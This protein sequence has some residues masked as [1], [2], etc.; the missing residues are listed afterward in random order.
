MAGNATLLLDAVTWDNVVDANGNFAVAGPPYSQA[1]D[2]AS[3]IRLW[4]GELYYDTTQGVPYEAILAKATNFKTLK[5]Y[6]VAAALT[7][8]GV[9]SAVCFISSIV[10]RTVSGQVTITNS[11]GQTATAAF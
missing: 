1:Q 6:M 2:A 4:L 9:V 8:P 3:T 7:V 5:S 11:A 10:G